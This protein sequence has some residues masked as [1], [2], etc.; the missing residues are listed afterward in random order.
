V[1][2]IFKTHQWRPNDAAN[3]QLTGD[4]LARHA[5]CIA[6]AESVTRAEDW[7]RATPLT[8]ALQLL[9]LFWV[10]HSIGCWAG[11]WSYAAYCDLPVFPMAHRRVVELA[12]GLPAE[13]LWKKDL[14][15]DIIRHEWP[16]LLQLP[17]NPP[18]LGK[19]VRTMRKRLRNVAWYFRSVLQRV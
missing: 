10:E 12:M 2:E 18:T 6:A 19:R 9:T 8:D 13:K 3:T 11:I 1:A 7:L 15:L 17:V 5:R 16:E 14:A 4:R